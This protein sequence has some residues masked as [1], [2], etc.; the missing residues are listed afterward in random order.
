[1]QSKYVPA[2]AVLQEGTKDAKKYL[3]HLHDTKVAFAPKTSSN[4]RKFG[5]KSRPDQDAD[6][7][8]VAI[9]WRKDTFEPLKLDFLAFDDPKRNQGA[10]RVMLRRKADGTHVTTIAAH[11]S[12]GS[13]EENEL[14]RLKECSQPSL[15]ATD[16]RPSGPSLCEWYQQSARCTPTVLAVDMNSAPKGGES[17]WR[18]LSSMHAGT[19]SALGTHYGLDGAPLLAKTMPVT[20]NKMRGPL[21][22]QPAKIGEHSYG[23]NTS[24]YIASL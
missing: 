16:G 11:L 1:M 20:T 4:C 9:F 21:S 2:H 3:K 24:F 13:S 12:S 5:L 7:D 8:G 10:V 22:S 19:R 18:R 14:A 6:N 17:V 15:N 23:K